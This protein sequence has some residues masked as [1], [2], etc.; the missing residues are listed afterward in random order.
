[1]PDEVSF[2]VEDLGTHTVVRPSG[3]LDISTS[4]RLREV[5]RDLPAGSGDVVILDLGSIE[6][7]DSS[8]LG[9]ILNG[10]KHM[11]SRDAT[12][13]V[14]SPQERITKIFEVTALTLSIQVYRSFEEAAAELGV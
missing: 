14:V 1:M 5:L 2:E 10:W 6:F 11:Q 9:V 4:P 8:A 7:L 12:L 13:V 3:F